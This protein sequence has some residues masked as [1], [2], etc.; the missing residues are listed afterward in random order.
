MAARGRRPH[1]VPD[2]ES[3]AD[4]PLV[5]D[6]VPIDLSDDED[7]NVNPAPRVQIPRQVP[8]ARSVNTIFVCHFFN[9]VFNFISFFVFMSNYI[10]TPLVLFSAPK[11]VSMQKVEKQCK[12]KASDNLNYYKL[13]S[14]HEVLRWPDVMISKQSML[15]MCFE[16][17]SC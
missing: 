9:L 4:E 3:D 6:S 1:V 11:M 8:D 12:D 10:I 17:E 13:L 16:L 15:S 5:T 2:S 14:V 7:I